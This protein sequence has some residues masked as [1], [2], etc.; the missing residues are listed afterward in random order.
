MAHETLLYPT[1]LA[2]PDAVDAL[3]ALLQPHIPYS[4]PILGYLFH[5]GQH[6]PNG[7][8]KPCVKVWTSTPQLESHIPAKGVFSV[9]LFT[10]ADHQ[11]RFFCSAESSESP[12]S[13]AEEGHVLS[14]ME[15]AMNIVSEGSESFRTIMP[16]SALPQQ[17][18][19]DDP[20][21][22][23]FLIGSVHEKWARCLQT[24]ALKMNPCAKFV[25]PP[26]PVTAIA[27]PGEE[28]VSTRL[29]E[30]DIE[31]VCAGSGVSRSR[32]Y[33]Q[34]RLAASVC[35]RAKTEMGANAGTPPV[36]WGLV[37]ADGS[38]GAL[39]VEDAHRRRGLGQFVMHELVRQI[40]GTGPDGQ[41]D[42]GGGALGWNWTDVMAANEKG[43]G[44][45]RSLG[46]WEERWVCYWVFLGVRPP[47]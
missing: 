28:Y 27:P 17:G 34:G 6:I 40:G 44:F 16:A 11:F 24:R 7:F 23:L 41:E 10:P 30:E 3:V 22:K 13:A 19:A 43:S 8:H 46:G 37:H 15:S 26:R 47:S 42:G 14:V 33:L 4:L 25:C 39:H 36:A 29:T 12:A 1:S 32:T 31:L 9:L 38:I 2:T 5:S 20:N 18:S 21:P 35:L 45:M